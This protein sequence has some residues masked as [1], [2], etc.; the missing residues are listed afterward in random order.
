MKITLHTLREFKRASI[1][2][3]IGPWTDDLDL[4]DLVTDGGSV[5]V[6][7]VHLLRDVDEVDS[8]VQRLSILHAN[9]ACFV[10]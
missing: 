6:F 7:A 8:V 5:E 9:V 2:H 3:R 10:A 1:F 4:T